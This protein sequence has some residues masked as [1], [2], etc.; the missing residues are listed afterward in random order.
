MTGAFSICSTHLFSSCGN[1]LSAQL[2][3]R[4]YSTSSSIV[5]L[6]LCQDGVV[7]GAML[8]EDEEMSWAGEKINDWLAL[9]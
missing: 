7:G 5:R 8:N 1:A 2:T 3:I 9:V 6:N 4:L